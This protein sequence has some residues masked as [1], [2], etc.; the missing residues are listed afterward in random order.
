MKQQHLE[1]L[2]L[3][4]SEYRF[5]PLTRALGIVL[6][7]CTIMGNYFYLRHALKILR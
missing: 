1:L 6:K 4:C 2:L 5:A 3:N 7:L